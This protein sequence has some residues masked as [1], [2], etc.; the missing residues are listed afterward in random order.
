MSIKSEYTLHDSMSNMVSQRWSDFS[1]SAVIAGIIAIVVGYAGPTVL[2]FQ[3]A[4]NAALSDAQVT[5]WLW[6]Y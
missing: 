6:A 2:V 1:L 3:V 5:S 4:Q